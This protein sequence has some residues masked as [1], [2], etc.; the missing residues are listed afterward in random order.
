MVVN[1][2]KNLCK[3][4]EKSKNYFPSTYYIKPSLV[5]FSNELK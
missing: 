4:I 5:T 3:D 2:M 1:K